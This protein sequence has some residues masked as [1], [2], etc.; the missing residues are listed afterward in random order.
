MLQNPQERFLSR[1]FR[2]V[3]TPELGVTNTID[4]LG[5]LPDKVFK[6]LVSAAGHGYDLAR[7]GFS[8]HQAFALNHEDH[9]AA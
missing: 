3:V 8:R 1:I 5:V 7:D 4:K 6:N 9:Q 2:L